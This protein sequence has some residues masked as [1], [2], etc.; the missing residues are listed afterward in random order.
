MKKFKKTFAFMLAVLFL[1]SIPCPAFAQVVD[2]EIA[3]RWIVSCDSGGKH[4]MSP[5][6]M[7]RLYSGT[8]NNPG[9][10]YGWGYLNQCTYCREVLWSTHQPNSTNTLG[11]YYISP[12]VKD[13]VPYYGTDLYMKDTG[14]IYYFNGNVLTDSYWQ[15]YQFLAN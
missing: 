9:T 5:R 15:G 8:I 1:V 6:A 11:N 14:T 13:V 10:N 4:Q 3:P 7:G 12:W 2:D